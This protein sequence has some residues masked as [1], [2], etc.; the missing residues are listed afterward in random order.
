MRSYLGN[1][2][3]VGLVLLTVA[4][5]LVFPPLSEGVQN[6]ER[7]YAGEVLGSLVIVLMSFSLFLSTR[8]KWAEPYF[9]GLDRMYLTHR[10]TST[11][12]FLLLFVHLLVVPIT[13]ANLRL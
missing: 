9:G 4:I 8:P 6:Y 13:V 1:S 10:R 5:W 11:G 7:A 3:I 12:A 2:L